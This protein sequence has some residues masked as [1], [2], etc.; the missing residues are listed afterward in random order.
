LQKIFQ[1]KTTNAHIDA[2]VTDCLQG[3]SAII[4]ASTQSVFDWHSLH[5]TIA[6]KNSAN[7]AVMF[8]QE[9]PKRR[10]AFGAILNTRCERKTAS[11]FVV[12][13]LQVSADSFILLRIPEV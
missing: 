6:K 2:H 12:K 11:K 9:Q 7:S 4:L 10:F 3:F 13:T 8:P 1:T 5:A